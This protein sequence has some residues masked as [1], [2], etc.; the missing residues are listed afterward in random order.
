MYYSNVFSKS[1]QS[2][3]QSPIEIKVKTLKQQKSREIKKE[4]IYNQA[5]WFS[6]ESAYH[7]NQMKSF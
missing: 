4:Y 1:R 2:H 5:R 6:D 3:N 7:F